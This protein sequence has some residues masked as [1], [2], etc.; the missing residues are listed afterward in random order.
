MVLMDYERRVEIANSKDPERQNNAWR[1]DI[2]GAHT[3]PKIVLLFSSG[4]QGATSKAIITIP[5]SRIPWARSARS[6][7]QSRA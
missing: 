2:Q 3:A 1:C 4:A 7:G 5:A 6:S